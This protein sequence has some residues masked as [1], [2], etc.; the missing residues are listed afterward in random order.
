VV[1]VVKGTHHLQWRYSVGLIMDLLHNDIDDL[2]SITLDD[3]FVT[4]NLATPFDEDTSHQT[5]QDVCTSFVETFLLSKG[6]WVSSLHHCLRECVTVLQG[7]EEV[8]EKFIEQL[9]YIQKDI[10]DVRENLAHTA[11]QL[12]NAKV[13]DRVLWKAVSRL[14]VPPEVVQVVTQSNDEE[15]GTQFA[16]TLR[17]LLKYLSYRQ[18]TWQLTKVASGLASV[19]CQTTDGALA[20]SAAR[21]A[22]NDA[23]TAAVE[24]QLSLTDC[25]IYNELLNVLDSLTVFA[26]IKV[27]AFLHRK[28]HILTIPDTNVCIQQEY[29]LK[30]Y[31]FYVH[32]LRA[33]P[34]L[35]R[36]AHARGHEDEKQPTL[37]PFRITRAIYIEFKQL[38]C[39]LMSAVY[40]GNVQ[41]YI[42]T[43]NAMEYSTSTSGS[44]A[45]FSVC[46][47][48]WKQF[49]ETSLS[50]MA[51]CTFDFAVLPA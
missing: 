22:I 36:Y 44:L 47:V 5:L 35:L 15:L 42:M 23:A 25:A 1:V 50:L 46:S 34:P 12:M 27:R 19:M 48:T 9:N 26:C 16:L 4:A 8:L 20:G 11:T 38:Y 45:F 30:Q 51:L 17:E 6:E 2:E 32:F 28:L 29:S 13:A 10:G 41:Q 40:Q 33:V 18:G 24:V 37:I 21:H 49:C 7:M 3:G 43:C 39:R 14:V 31:G